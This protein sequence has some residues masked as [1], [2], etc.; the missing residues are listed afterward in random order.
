MDTQGPQQEFLSLIRNLESAWIHSG[1]PYGSGWS[2]PPI[3]TCSLLHQR[4]EKCVSVR[5]HACVIET[6]YHESRS[7]MVRS[8]SPEISTWQC[9]ERLSVC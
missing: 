8:G 2:Q 1:Q 4:W 5:A 9:V 6:Y 3:T 7:Q